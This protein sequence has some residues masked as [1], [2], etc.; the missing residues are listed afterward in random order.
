MRIG[1]HYPAYRHRLFGELDGIFAAKTCGQRFEPRLKLPAPR[2]DCFGASA[3]RN[4][5]VVIEGP[6]PHRRVI[7][8]TALQAPGLLRIRMSADQQRDGCVAPQGPGGGSF[9][10]QH[11]VYEHLQ[12]L[13]VITDDHV[14]PAVAPDKTLRGPHLVHPLGLGG[15]QLESQRRSRLCAEQVV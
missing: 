8:L 14:T 15:A 13:A 10:G 2:L 3:E 4:D 1:G 5:A 12:S 9:I 6:I 11:A 7:D